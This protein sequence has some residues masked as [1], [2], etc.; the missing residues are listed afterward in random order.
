M[1]LLYQK[2]TSAHVHAVMNISDS[3]AGNLLVDAILTG[4]NVFAFQVIT[5]RLAKFY[6]TKESKLDTWGKE[7]ENFTRKEPNTK[8]IGS[9]KFAS[10][11][12]ERWF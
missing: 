3:L 6:F 11:L 7:K 5:N 8:V 1:S 2:M 9:W 12:V 10:A 4:T